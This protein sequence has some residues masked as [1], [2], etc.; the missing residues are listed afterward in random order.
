MARR[1]SK[2]GEKSA[3]ET[4]L[5]HLGQAQFPLL[6]DVASALYKT[7]KERQGQ[8]LQHLKTG[9]LLA[10]ISWLPEAGPTT[11]PSQLWHEIPLR[12]FKVRSFRERHWVRHKYD[13]PLNLVYKH[14]VGPIIAE[15]QRDFFPRDT[16]SKAVSLS[17]NRTSEESL[18]SQTGAASA[19][20][21]LY[22]HL[23]QPPADLTAFVTREAA[24]KFASSHLNYSNPL[25]R[26]GRKPTNNSDELL[27]EIFR[28]ITSNGVIEL[29]HQKAFCNSML[30]WWNQ[31]SK[32][33]LRKIDWIT[34]H[35]QRVWTIINAAKT[36]K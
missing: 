24:L 10:S 11:I 18:A 28:R 27:L 30:Q 35:V 20:Q 22:V 21:N 1:K 6:G 9:T 7:T 29:P 26:R 15:M 33:T 36:L 34:E 23:S 16:A 3:G 5:A 12:Q 8:V 19:L 32:R 4:F 13:L 14:C 25:E 2:S 17:S 31:D